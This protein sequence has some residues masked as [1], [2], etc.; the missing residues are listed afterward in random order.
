MNKELK[1]QM[2]G[3]AL[4]LRSCADE[5]TKSISNDDEQSL[6]HSVGAASKSLNLA[7]KLTSELVHKSDLQQT[8]EDQIKADIQ[9]ALKHN[10][11]SDDDISEG[12]FKHIFGSVFKVQ[13]QNGFNNAL[14]A[15]LGCAEND[16]SAL[17]YTKK[18]LRESVQSWPERYPAFVEFE[19]KM[20][21]CKRVY[22]SVS[23]DKNL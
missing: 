11:S 1:Q 10:Q 13:N 9:D 17:H 15:A 19:D 7:V 14:Y 5:I 16:G 21:E 18:E 3:L 22:V 4:Y 6:V 2:E 12:N 23:Y 20:L 8:M